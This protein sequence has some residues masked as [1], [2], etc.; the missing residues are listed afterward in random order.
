MKKE[1]YTDRFDTTTQGGT[2]QRRGRRSVSSVSRNDIM[3]TIQS[4]IRLIRYRPWLFLLTSLCWG[5]FHALPLAAGLLTREIFNELGGK[6]EVG[7]D[8]WTLLALVVGVS[9]ARVSIMIGGVWTWSTLFFTLGSLMRRNML[10][11]LVDGPGTR[12]V[13]A[14]PG[15][16]VSR[17]RDD[18]D[19]VMEFVE[20]W[21][22]FTGFAITAV[23]AII[24][25]FMIAP[26][27]TFVVLVPLAGMLFFGHKM[28]GYI[29]KY[30]KANREATGRITSF[31]G[32]VFGAV[33]AVKVASAEDRVLR[34]FGQLNDNREKVA[35]KDALFSEIFRSVN[36]NMIN[37][38][39]GL[40]LI[41]A[42]EGMRGGSFSLGDFALFVFFLQRL[43]W[44]MFFFGDMI[45][46]YRRTGVSIDRMNELMVDAPD[47]WLTHHAPLDKPSEAETAGRR[48][49]GMRALPGRL[50]SLVVRDLTYVHPTSGKGI[51]GVDLEIGR[52]EFVVITGRIGAGKTT[53]IRVLLGLLPRDRG[54]ILWNGI[55]VDDPATEM[56]PPLAAYTP[57]APRLFSDSLRD[58]ILMGRP[59]PGTELDDAIGL[60][61]MDPDLAEL[62]M[63]LETGVGPRGVKLSGGQVQ[64][65]AAAR[66][67]VREPELLVFDDLSSAL[68]V[69][70][71]HR[72]WAGLFE[73]RDS[74]CLV[75]SHRH[76]A[77]RRAD[78]IYVM[79]EGE[80]ID[81][82]RLDELLE[83]CDEMR[84]L[85]AGNDGGSQGEELV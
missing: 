21:T 48:R 5:C 84:N 60:A 23:V 53:L 40:V 66:M 75:A 6:G 72:L 65:S 71:E 28:G 29:R 58:N 70:T 55:Q 81:A 19:E 8:V 59:T 12:R 38:G 80:V 78:R 43:T 79:K 85:W 62:E 9:L 76:A 16:S 36:A 20:G 10:A 31:I 32:E 14:S 46:Q 39:T 47:G 68:D 64:R 77:L 4:T 7:F 74:A 1:R 56:T 33:Q 69:E 15:E 34:H 52:S 42:A 82:G 24:I 61:V 35:V 54:K 63:G 2:R 22:D 44:S 51:A 49:S 26:T 57:Q 45:A 13:P 17:F 30:R 67:L 3:T 27:I 18:V 50:E 41:L 73:R 11:W 25:M 37:I 83:R